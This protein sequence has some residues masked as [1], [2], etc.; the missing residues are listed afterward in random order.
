MEKVLD[1]VASDE[2]WKQQLLDDPEE[3]MQE[4]GFPEAERLREM[5]AS[6]Q[7][8]Q[9]GEEVRGQQ[10]NC[11]YAGFTGLPGPNFVSKWC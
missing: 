7:S 3:V 8:V 9:E 6:A 4:A 5:Q 10:L 2:R 11:V 1:R